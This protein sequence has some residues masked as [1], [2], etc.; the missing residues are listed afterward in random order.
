MLR[1]EW[2]GLG[3]VDGEGK[4]YGY[5]MWPG[6]ARCCRAMVGGCCGQL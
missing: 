1:L 4:V 5:P 6:H 2:K 3:V